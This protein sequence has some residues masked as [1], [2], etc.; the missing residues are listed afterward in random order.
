MK[1]LVLA[2]LAASLLAAT[3]TAALAMG[4]T[5][6]ST[7]SRSAP[8]ATSKLN[9]D[10]STALAA[11]QKAANAG[12]M[13]GAMAQLKIAQAVPDRGAYDDFV[14]SQFMSAVAAN[15]RDY[16]TAMAAYNTMMASP[17]FADLSDDD[18]KLAYHDGM[19][20]A[21][22]VQ[23]WAKVIEFGGKLDAMGG[24]DEVTY[25]AVA[26][27]YYNG[28]DGKNAAVYAQKAIDFATA[29]NKTAP[30]QAMQLVVNGQAKSDPAAAL[31]N[32]E[33]I[34]VTNNDPDVWHRI[35]QHELGQSGVKDVDALY[36]YRLQYTAGAMQE[37]D[38]FTVMAS[39]AQQLGYP[40]EA[41]KTYEQGMASG[42]LSAGQA[43]AGLSKARRDAAAD[44]RALGQI[45]ASAEKSKT[46][47]QDVKLAED[48]W[49]YGRY[50]DAEAAARRGIAKGGI[51]DPAEGNM[52]LGQT[53]VAQGKFD[54]AIATFALVSGSAARSYTAHV[55]SLYAQA[56][57][58]QGH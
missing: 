56:R 19:I 55:W 17:S 42:K 1:R 10:V 30:E 11:A 9:K 50:A 5:P 39:L 45:A 20:V 29:H 31:A 22:N 2:A 49:G 58:K 23:Q 21:E 38:D 54:D 46:G 53:L 27:G 57:K 34:A 12:D 51:K 44:E 40:T 18:K 33:K 52:I 25:T 24:M 14:I 28:N 6:H 16:P 47:D 4:P 43:G 35:I 15:L 32:L 37:G 26:I 3:S 8:I 13:Q 41:Q 48:Y 36:L 7:T